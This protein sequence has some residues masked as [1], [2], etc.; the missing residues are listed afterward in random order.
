M[1]QG[2]NQQRGNFGGLGFILA[3]AGS[4]IGLGNIW[5]FPYIAYQNNGGSFVLVYLAAIVLIG[6]PIM[7]AE[8][9]IGRRTQQSPVGAFLS[10]AKSAGT[11][12]RWAWIGWLGILSGLTILSYYAVVAGWTV[13]Y[14]GK[15]LVWSTTGFTEEVAANLGPDFGSFLANGPLQILFH[16]LF[17][18]ATIGVVMMG[19]KAGI[20]RTT[21]ILMPVLLAILLVMVFA[22]MS[23]PG[24]GEAISFLFHIGPIEADGLLEAVGHAFFTLSLGMGAMI[25]YGSYVSRRV[26]IPKAAATICILD[27]V[28]ALMASLIMFSII[29]SVPMAERAGTFTRSAS[30]LF[31]TLPKMFYELPFGAILSPVFYLLVAMAAL[32]STISLLE[33][34]VS[35]FIDVK[36]WARRKATLA[37][38]GAIFLLGVP[39]ALSLGASSGLSNI[40]LKPQVVGFFSIVDYLASNWFLPLG[41]LGLALFTGWFLKS[42]LSKEEIEV[43]HGPFR[44]HKVWLF[45]LRFVC[46]VAILWIIWAVINGR[47]FA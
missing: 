7:L 18:A 25:T 38:G 17:M 9:L 16:G 32:T 43:G 44:L 34:V 5:K 10:L 13:Y 8:I 14:F 40:A 22:S 23:S 47:S 21:K 26:S 41:G 11:S 28:I 19:V 46:P 36:G 37:V 39:S 6:V 35:Y 24:F 30:I 45:L 29:F 20:E 2:D 3:A 27:T 31:T 1:A 42:K 4:A 12:P 33:V 15:C